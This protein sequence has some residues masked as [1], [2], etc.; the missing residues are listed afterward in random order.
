MTLVGPDIQREGECEAVLRSLPDWFGIEESLMAYARDSG[1][2]PTFAVEAPSGLAGF[3]T[4]RQHF[5]QSWEIHCLAIAADRRNGGL[6]TRLLARAESW[7]AERGARF[8]QVKTIAATSPNVPYA[9]TR[10][11]YGRRGFVPLEVFPLLWDPRNPA[12]LFVKSL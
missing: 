7:L 1:R 9:Q 4:L 11:F 10:E 3:L 6:G 2:L 12:L 8:L 5:P